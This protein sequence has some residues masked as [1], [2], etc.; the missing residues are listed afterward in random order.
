MYIHYN[1]KNIIEN[2]EGSL[3]V[4]GGGGLKAKTF[5]GICEAKFQKSTV[6]NDGYFLNQHNMVLKDR[7]SVTDTELLIS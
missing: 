1:W 6:Q 3:G 4:G 2:S 5:K 7:C